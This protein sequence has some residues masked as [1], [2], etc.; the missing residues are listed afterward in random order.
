MSITLQNYLLE[1]SSITVGDNAFWVDQ[2]GIIGA[3]PTNTKFTYVA[4]PD[5]AFTTDLFIC[6][7]DD[8]ARKAFLNSYENYEVISIIYYIKFKLAQPTP[9]PDASISMHMS[10]ALD[11]TALIDVPSYLLSTYSSSDS[12][13]KT[14]KIT[15]DL[16]TGLPSRSDLLD[17]VSLYARFGFSAS[18]M[19]SG[20]EIIYV[21]EISQ[22]IELAE[23]S[24]PSIFV[25]Y[26][27]SSVESSTAIDLGT[28]VQNSEA[29]I[30][31]SIENIGSDNLT[32]NYFEI[33]DAGIKE[34]VST[35][36][37]IT[38]LPK[39]SENITIILNTSSDGEFQDQQVKISNDSLNQP[40][41]F[42]SV[43]FKVETSSETNTPTIS[44]SY[45]STEIVKNRTFS[46]ASVPLDIAKTVSILC[47]NSGQSNLIISGVTI[48]GDAIVGAGT[49]LSTGATIS[50]LGSAVLNLSVITSTLSNK[51]ISVSIFSNDAAN[52][53]F[54]F[55]IT[56]SVLPQSN[57][58]FSLDNVELVDGE[59]FDIGSIDR[60]KSYTKSYVLTNSGIYKNL[61]ID[62]LTASSDLS[63]VG[64]YSLP[65]TLSPNSA[66]SLVVTVLFDTITVGLRDG[67]FTINY[68]E[69]SVPS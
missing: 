28:F 51:S 57:L 53:P 18:G 32:I 44:L 68:S 58:T 4:S 8:D 25:S 14:A 64:T 27:G 20:D 62:S 24:G 35:A 40:A 48:S 69:G 9:S 15:F 2:S 38:I 47:Y 22:T 60:G 52:N 5:K 29:Q 50:P 33:A 59:E 3:N 26:N 65:F 66:N 11:E 61:L 54:T 1:P 12:D 34:I 43:S 39:V 31:F 46:I 41:F 56:Y 30:T 10:L 23:I 6:R 63:I 21:H 49:T 42:I 45:E 19:L 67:I 37:P 55:T 17:A 13:V 36:T 7:F 16:T